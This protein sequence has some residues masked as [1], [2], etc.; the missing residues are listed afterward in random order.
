[1][2]IRRWLPRAWRALFLLL[3]LDASAMADPACPHTPG[4]RELAS[5]RNVYIGEMHGTQEVAPL[6]RCLVQAALDR[7]A[8][9][10]VVSLELPDWDRPEG[11]AHWQRVHDG[12]TSQATWQF[13]Q[14]LRAQEA[15]G[16]LRIHYQYDGAEL[17]GD[18]A[19][20][21]RHVGG[22]IKALIDQ[23]NAV[24]AWGGNFHSRREADSSMPGPVP[25]GAVIGS[26]ILHVDVVSSQGGEVWACLTKS[27][28]SGGCGVHALPSFQ[29]PDWQAGAL[30][31]GRELGHDKLFVVPRFSASLPQF[32]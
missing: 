29:R 25:T 16:R 9:S 2:N 3:A 32:P 15:A 17:L 1:M 8:K 5:A 31:D 26:S 4:F 19:A 13:Y 30:V 14:W 21:E 12:K 24:I 22:A 27:D 23:G 11:K 7:G 28:G 18:Q 6:L 10:L 20:Y